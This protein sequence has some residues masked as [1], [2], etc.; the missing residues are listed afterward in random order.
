MRRIAATTAVSVLALA[1]V[2]LLVFGVLQTADDTSL[3]QAVAHGERPAAHDA[4][5]PLLDGSG[6]RSLADYRTDDGGYVVVNFFASWCEPCEAEASLLN[7]LQRRLA[8][9]GTIVGVSWNDSTDDS[10]E[11][12][13]EHGVR[14]PVVR[15]VDD[16]F[17]RAYGITGLPETFVV[18]PEGRIVALKRSQLTPEW[19]AAEIDPLIKRARRA[20]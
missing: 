7:E 9:R 6:S 2:A 10:R 17:G 16:S 12:L 13:R 19:I 8:G 5:L 1:L 14:F 4:P 20:Q 3:D 18:D 15:D 11:F